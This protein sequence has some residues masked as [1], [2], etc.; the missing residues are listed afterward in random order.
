MKC[1]YLMER[2]LTMCTAASVTYLPSILEI[3]EYCTVHQHTDCPLFR[4]VTEEGE[5]DPAGLGI[6]PLDHFNT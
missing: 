4:D 2:A 3:A 5:G 1:P 6:W